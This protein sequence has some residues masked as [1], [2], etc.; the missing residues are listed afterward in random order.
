VRTINRNLLTTLDWNINSDWGVTFKVPLLS[1]AHKHIF[2]ADN[3]TGGTDPE[4]EKWNFSGIG[5]VQALARYRFYADKDSNAGI[6]FGLKL[7]TGSIHKR[8]S[9]EEAERTLQPGSGSVDSLL[10][11]YYNR[12]D[13][14][15]GWFAQG[16]WQQT[17]SDRDGFKPGTKL[18]A[19]VGSS[20]NATPDLSLMLQLNA[21][22][23]FK[24]SGA[25]A[26]PAD[27]G[28]STLSLSPGLSYRV[29]AGTQVYG[30]LQKPIYQYV[31]G[32]QLTAGWSVAFGVNTSF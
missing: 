13:G 28:S 10:G 31:N 4:L 8:N 16:T 5:D 23:K 1:R 15:I 30:F 12:H 27:S 3:G 26:E 19:D 2:N 11:A 20:Y 18:S 25:N 24:D 21:L 32:A 6:R 14:N 22:H 9:E 29:T 17:V 7:P